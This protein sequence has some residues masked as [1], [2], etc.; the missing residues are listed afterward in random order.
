MHF[1]PQ[2]SLYHLFDCSSFYH[3]HY[4]SKLKIFS[5]AEFMA[6]KFTTNLNIYGCLLFYELIAVSFHHHI[7]INDK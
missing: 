1:S 6:K 5:R 2:S 4:F 7:S 3:F